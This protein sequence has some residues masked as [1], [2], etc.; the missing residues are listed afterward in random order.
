MRI[1]ASSESSGSGSD[2]SG[3]PAMGGSRRATLEA[4]L[5]AILPDRL[6]D[7]SE[8]LGD[9]RLIDAG[10]LSVM[11]STPSAIDLRPIV[12]PF[13]ARFVRFLAD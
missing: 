5:P 13:G 1:Q 8:Q 11:V 3:H 6:R 7:L 4:R 12:T 9:L 10:M 2:S